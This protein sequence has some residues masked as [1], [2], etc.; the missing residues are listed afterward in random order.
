[1]NALQNVSILLELA[2][3]ILGLLI[4]LQKKKSYGAFIFITF[5]LYM[6]YD[7]SRLWNLAIPELILRLLFA[8]ASLS[9]LLA[10]WKLYKTE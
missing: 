1:M 2:V 5:L 7:A 10:V 3:A 9:I 8:V 4:W 6:V